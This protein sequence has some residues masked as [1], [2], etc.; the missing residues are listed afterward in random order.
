M[1]AKQRPQRGR[2]TGAFKNQKS[3]MTRK[4][5]TSVKIPDVNNK[6]FSKKKQPE[7]KQVDRGTNLTDQMDDMDDFE[8][9]TGETKVFSGKALTAKISVMPP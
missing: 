8:E 4:A 7:A 9:E 2:Q 6:N 1:A 5:S 3:F